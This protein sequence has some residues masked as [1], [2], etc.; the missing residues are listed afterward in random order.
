MSMCMS[1]CKSMCMSMIMCM[2]MSMSCYGTTLLGCASGYD[3]E[4]G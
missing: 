3:C 2:C 4:T 1:M